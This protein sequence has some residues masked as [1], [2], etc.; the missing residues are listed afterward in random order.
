MM[1]IKRVGSGTLILRTLLKKPLSNTE[2]RQ[3]AFDNRTNNSRYHKKF[4]YF[5]IFYK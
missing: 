3:V 2:I 1:G 5:E 4:K